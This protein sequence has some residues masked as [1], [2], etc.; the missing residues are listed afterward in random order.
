MKAITKKMMD[1]F[2]QSIKAWK[3]NKQTMD[4]K[5]VYAKDRKDLMQ[6]YKYIEKKEYDKAY[7]KAYWLDTVVRDQIPTDIYNFLFL[8]ICTE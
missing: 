3:H 1:D 2:K 8:D 7:D 4:I 6:V 5:D